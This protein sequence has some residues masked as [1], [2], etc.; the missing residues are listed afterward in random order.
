MKLFVLILSF[1]CAVT[2]SAGDL[3][4]EDTQDSSSTLLFTLEGSNT[5]GGAL[6]PAWVKAF[7]QAKG[8]KSIGTS[9]LSK[10][11]EYR[12][13]ADWKQRKVHIDI[14]AHGSSTGFRGLANGSADIAMSSRAIRAEET[15]ALAKLGDLTSSESEHVVAIDGLAVIVHPNNPVA[16]LSLERLA[17]VFSGKITNWR[18]LGGRDEPISVYARDDNS[19]TWDTFSALVL[20]ERYPLSTKAYRFESNDQLSASV[21]QDQGAI[22]FVGLASV[23]ASKAVAIFD[24]ATEALAPLP[25][26]VATEDYPLARRLYLYTASEPS[27]L[28]REFVHF[29]QTALGQ[30]VVEQI[31]F[32]AQNP[33]QL[34]VENLSGPPF[35][36]ELSQHAAR[37]SVNLRFQPGSAELDNKAKRDVLRL[38]G[39]L[40]HPDNRALRVQLVGFSDDE[41]TG[42]LADV[43]SKLRAT[44]V[45]SE[46]FRHGV[47]TEAVAGF[48]ASRPVAE[49]ADARS[50]ND[51]VEVWVYARDRAEVIDAMRQRAL[52]TD[53][54]QQNGS[55]RL[56]KR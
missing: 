14:R 24:G 27:E 8:A 10:P 7:F 32:V 39:Y 33:L 47:V 18:E 6:A 54:T 17:Q 52:A 55:Q 38:V 41:K 56:S 5:V 31:G 53:A 50:K 43:L 46:L 1:F 44:A 26:H 13:S 15:R 36:R 20:G 37:L 21:A 48:G 28:V 35:Y 29:A 34:T 19:G 12:I 30:S 23:N 4:A 11:N 49:T 42:A 40:T 51:R 9:P 22:G 16:A 3:A 25:L 45:K 2:F